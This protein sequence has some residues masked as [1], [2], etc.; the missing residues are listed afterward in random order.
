M[1]Q[2]QN[3]QDMIIFIYKSPNPAPN[4]QVTSCCRSVLLNV[5]YHKEYHYI[6]FRGG[7]LNGF[8]DI[9]PFMKWG[10]A[11]PGMP[12]GDFLVSAIKW[13]LS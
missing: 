5:S 10:G 12:Q 7:D 2:D 1:P 9:K 11:F 3:E 13:V 6:W 4:S 8:P